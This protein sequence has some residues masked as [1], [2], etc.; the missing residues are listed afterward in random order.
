MAI[1]KTF[2][3]DDGQRLPGRPG[4][5]RTEY[6]ERGSGL[7]LRIA[8]TGSRTWCVAYYAKA[9][10]TTRRLKLAAARLPLAKARKLAR[11]ALVAVEAGRDPFSEALAAREL[12]RKERSARREERERQKAERERR[13]ITFGKL[14][15]DYVEW[16]RTTPGGRRKKT[17]SQNT[18]RNWDSM[19][20]L[21]ILPVVGATPAEDVT[22]KH[23][24]RVTEGAVKNGGPS[25]GQQTRYLLSAVWRWAESRARLL[26]VRLPPESP[27]DPL[28]RDIGTASEERERF[29]S[30]VEVWRFWRA[31][32]SEGLAG[33]ALRFSLLTA[34]RVKE[35]TE[36]PW[37]EVDLEAKTWTLPAIRNKGGRVRVVPLSDQALALLRRVQGRGDARVFGDARIYGGGTMKR[38]RVAMGGEPWEARDLRRTASTHAARL[39]ADPFVVAMLLGHARADP[40][41]P[42]VTKA[43]LRWNYDDRVRDAFERLGAW[44]DETVT[45]TEP[46]KLVEFSAR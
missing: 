9:A 15:A 27:L 3:P 22:V 36:L 26:G 5:A 34:A 20:S 41:V 46:G 2:R 7:R 45:A 40:R 31:T 13:S 1:E 10:K 21:H 29:L 4:E 14:C 33:E 12:E 28:P 32:E 17:A 24:F 8:A 39:G 42:R 25:M 38:V 19:L 44:I 43:Y 37:S 23:F 35:A 18:L 6:L 16:R 30:P 11:A